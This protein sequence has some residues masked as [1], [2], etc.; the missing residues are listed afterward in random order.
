MTA[1]EQ[2]QQTWQHIGPRVAATIEGATKA[3]RPA[4]GSGVANRVRAVLG[5]LAAHGI[6]IEAWRDKNSRIRI[7]IEADRDG[8]GEPARLRIV[9][10]PPKNASWGTTWSAEAQETPVLSKSQPPWHDPTGE[11]T[12]LSAP[13]SSGD[14]WIE[15]IGKAAIKLTGPRTKTAA[16]MAEPGDAGDTRRTA[17]AIETA[18]NAIRDWSQGSGELTDERQ[19]R[20]L[21]AELRRNNTMLTVYFRRDG[22][23]IGAGIKVETSE[24][25]Q[26][27]GTAQPILVSGGGR[28]RIAELRVN[29]SGQVGANEIGVRG[30]AALQERESQFENEEQ[31]RDIL[32]LITSH[33]QLVTLENATLEGPSPWRWI[34]EY[35]GERNDSDKTTAI[36]GQLGW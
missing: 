11:S 30:L 26:L 7:V 33:S 10:R 35:A 21:S 16:A 4:G 17:T 22:G 12:R 36:S 31:I 27:T 18:L 9:G 20:S 2:A 6:G 24:Q 28:K 15:R 3:A 13:Q 29:S 14:D 23:P 34:G 25:T 1:A 32:G 5:R 8:G 19:L